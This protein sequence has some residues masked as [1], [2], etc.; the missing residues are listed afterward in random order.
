MRLLAEGLIDPSAD[1]GALQ[2]PVHAERVE[3][4]LT[5]IACSLTRQ[6]PEVVAPWTLD[7]IRAHHREAMRG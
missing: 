2:S 7:D 6:R 4:L 1:C 5:M 3:R